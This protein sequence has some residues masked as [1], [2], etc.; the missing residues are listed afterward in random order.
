MNVLAY[1]HIIYPLKSIVKPHVTKIEYYFCPVEHKLK[2]Q[3]YKGA[4]L[5]R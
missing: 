2:R 4:I 3:P 5:W 1:V